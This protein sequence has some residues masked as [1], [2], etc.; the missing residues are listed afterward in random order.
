MKNN[1][2]NIDIVWVFIKAGTAGKMIISSTSKTK[3]I[4]ATIKNR[5][6]KGNRAENLGVNPHS[7]GLIFSRSK[8]YLYL[9]LKPTPIRILANRPIEKNIKAKKIIK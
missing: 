4:I 9:R 7:K 2:A 8:L 3:K 5:I 1:P 6:E